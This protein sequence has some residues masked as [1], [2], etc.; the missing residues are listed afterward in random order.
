METN[1]TV[2]VLDPAAPGDPVDEGASRPYQARLALAG[3]LSPPQECAEAGRFEIIGISAGEGNG[4]KFGEDCLRES[5]GLWEGIE[6]FIDH[7]SFWAG[8]SV[9]DLAGVCSSPSWDAGRK[10]IKLQLRAAGPSGPLLE[11]IA[12]E[13]LG[14]PGPKPR[15]GFSADVLFTAQ[16]REVKQLLRIISLDLVFNPARGGAFL[17]ALNSQQEDSTMG[18]ENTT[19]TQALFDALLGVTLAGSKLPE[20]AAKLIRSRFEGQPFTLA[21]LNHE[22]DAVRE[23]T[24]AVQ[25]P[26]IIQGPALSGQI[27][28]MLTGEERLQAAVDDLFEAPRDEHMQTARVERLSGIRELYVGLTGDTSIAGE[29]NPKAA[30]FATTATLPNLIKNAMNKIVK[31]QADVLG[32]AGYLWWKPIVTIEHFDNLNQITGTFV[33]EI[34]AL[35]SVAEGAEY[36]ELPVADIAEVGNWTK[37]GGYVPLTLELIDRDNLGKLKNYPRKMTTAAIRALSASI[38][39]IFT[40]NSGAG[41][42]MSDSYNVFHANHSNVGTTALASAEWEVACKAVYNQSMLVASGQTAP[43]LAIDPRYLLVPRALRLAAYQILYPQM[44]RATNIF[45]QNMQQGQPGDVI[46]V[47]DWTDVTDW[48]VVCDPKLAPAIYVG[49]RFGTTPEVFIAGDP[50]SPAMFANDEARLKVRF[51]VSV[52]VADYRPMYKENVAG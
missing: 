30:K 35:P 7:G 20:P 28:G 51:F 49:E 9:K 31:D 29:Y 12:R 40:A 13:W 10:A 34:G 39:S 37:Y 21:Q 23:L 27:T 24:A 3:Q 32:Q 15:L 11:S 45:T 1:L 2:A 6:T 44:E 22:I 48:A 17:R 26:A 41:P 18:E 19:N 43:K 14:A 38:A 8:R 25:A 47:P 16:G 42:V 46:T 5:L 4:W 33:S 50:S 36:V 52:F